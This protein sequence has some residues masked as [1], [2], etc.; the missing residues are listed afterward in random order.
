MRTRIQKLNKLFL[1]IC[2]F[3]CSSVFAFAT[4]NAI[5]GIDV[6]Q[7]GPS[8]YDVVLKTNADVDIQKMVNG[9]D[10]LTIILKDTVPTESVDIIYD[11]AADLENVIVQ[12]KN[13]GNTVIFLQGKD[14]ENAQV[15]T[16]DIST[17][18]VL[19]SDEERSLDNYL[20]IADK[21]IAGFSV[22]GLV[23]FF[24]IM[25]SL[26]PKN[27]RYNS[28]VKNVKTNKSLSENTLR[29]KNINQ[30]R[31][32]PSINYKLNGGFSRMSI[33]KDFVI[34]NH[35]ANEKKQIRKAG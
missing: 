6:R 7:L 26:R 3:L 32:I 29:N 22:L 23:M 2:I 5:S 31:S 13:N 4:E 14:I 9:E 21:K 33:P 30:S 12:K 16:K 8:N 27:K 19:P 24:M 18:A 34:N 17:G 10:N 15:Y 20:F 35:M 25:L 11:N 1:F 28:N